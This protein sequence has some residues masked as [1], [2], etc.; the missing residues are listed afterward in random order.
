MPTAKPKPPPGLA[1]EGRALWSSVTADAATQQLELDAR[2]QRWLLDACRI[3]DQIAA[4]TAALEGEPMTVLGSQRQLV[5]H[6]LLAEIRQ[7]RATLAMT[8]ARLKLDPPEGAA[9]TGH[10]YTSATARDAAFKR[11]RNTNG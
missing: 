1:T 9:A 6:P 7:H 5:A 4:M 3:A 11:W 10:K 2:E 8:L